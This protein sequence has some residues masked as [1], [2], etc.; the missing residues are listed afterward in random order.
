MQKSHLVP[1]LI[2]AAITLVILV[3]LTIALHDSSTFQRGEF[4]NLIEV[5]FAWVL[6]FSG[7]SLLIF[8]IISLLISGAMLS[9][10]N[11]Y[12]KWFAL[13]ILSLL[14]MHPA[15]YLAFGVVIILITLI[16]IDYLKGISKTSGTQYSE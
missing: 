11:S 3:I 5:S 4:L 9:E 13:I 12:A 6:R 14:I 10:K 8:S 15:W 16:V 7:L 2:V 1:F